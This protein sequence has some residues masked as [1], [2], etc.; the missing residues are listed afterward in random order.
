MPSNFSGP[1]KIKLEHLNCNIKGLPVTS[2]PI[3]VSLNLKTY[4]LIIII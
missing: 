4:L 3:K 2:N 1:Y